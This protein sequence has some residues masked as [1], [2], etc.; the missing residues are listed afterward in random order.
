M[1]N[2]DRDRH[3]R[4][5]PGVAPHHR[6]EGASGRPVGDQGGG[7]RGPQDPVSPRSHRLRGPAN[8]REEA[9]GQKEGWGLI[10]VRPY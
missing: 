10:L 8:R 1:K 5:P 7:H 6:A 2:G 9:G 3:Q 4:Q